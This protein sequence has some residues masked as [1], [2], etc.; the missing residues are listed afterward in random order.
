MFECARD[1]SGVMLLDCGA[2]VCVFPR[3]E[4]DKVWKKAARIFLGNDEYVETEEHGNHP[5]WGEGVV[6][7]GRNGSLV[8]F[9]RAV[10]LFNVDFDNGRNVFT[11]SDKEEGNPVFSA[12]CTNGLYPLEECKTTSKIFRVGIVKQE[13]SYQ[14]K[15]LSV[16]KE[17]HKRLAHV[18]IRRILK[19]VQCYEGFE[20]LEHLVLPSPEPQCLPCLEAENGI[21]RDQFPK[22]AR[23]HNPKPGPQPERGI[24]K[25]V[26][27]GQRLSL[28]ILFVKGNLYLF[29][30]EF[31]TNLLLLYRLANKKRESIFEGIR[32]FVG[33]LK[34]FGD[35]F[36]RTT[37]IYSDHEVVFSNLKD[38]LTLEGITLHQSAPYEHQSIIETHVRPL[39]RYMIAIER[40]IFA[41]YQLL[42]P[43]E[44]HPYLLEYCV[45]MM[46]L[47]PNSKT[48]TRSDNKPPYLIARNIDKIRVPITFGTIACFRDPSQPINLIGMVIGISL[49]SSS[50]LVYF[51]QKKISLAWRRRGVI[52]QHDKIPLWFR[53]FFDKGTSIKIEGISLLDPKEESGAEPFYSPE[54]LEALPREDEQWPLQLED[55]STS[56]TIDDSTIEEED[57]IQEEIIQEDLPEE[58]MAE[59]QLPEG[60]ENLRRSSRTRRSTTRS[61]YHYFLFRKEA[62]TLA[63]VLKMVKAVD[64]GVLNDSH[65]SIAE[66]TEL[67]KEDSPR[68][69][70]AAKIVELDNV[71]S[72]DTFVPQDSASIP[73]D[74]N[75]IPCS[76]IEARKTTASGEF[77]S[78]KGR[79]VAGGH[80]DEQ[81]VPTWSPTVEPRNVMLTLNVGLTMDYGF[82]V[83]DV[84][85]AYL[86]ATLDRPVYMRIP[87]KLAS[88]L[89]TLKPEWNRFKNSNGSLI[90]LLKKALY[91]LADSGRQF[92]LELRKFLVEDM[93]FQQSKLDK[94]VYWRTG[95]TDGREWIHLVNTHVDDLL[96]TA[97][98]KQREEFAAKLQ[99]RFGSIKHQESEKGDVTFLNMLLQFL[100]PGECLISQPDLVSKIVKGGERIEKYPAAKDINKVDP[101]SPMMDDPLAFRS[102]LMQIQYLDR[103]RPDI[104]MAQNV[105]ATRMK[106]PSMQDWE[107]LE[108]LVAYIRGT[109]DYVLR[110]APQDGVVNPPSKLTDAN[111]QIW[112]SADASY[113]EN[114][115]RRSRTGYVLGIGCMPNAPIVCKSV[116]QTGTAVSSTEA[117]LNALFEATK[118]GIAARN[119]MLEKGFTQV[120][121][122]YEQDNASAI[123]IAETG[124]TQ[125]K[126]TKHMD[127]RMNYI[128]ERIEDKSIE[129]VKV[130][131]HD[132]LADY[133][134]KV[135]HGRK[136]I[137]WRKRIMNHKY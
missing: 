35:H 63:T 5:I 120:A 2:N 137:E 4:C 118:A 128:T 82:D 49:E 54:M 83:L 24:P 106:N 127:I 79:L 11:L 33:R 50:V 51:P 58:P 113:G 122:P 133:L 7:A 85:S 68:G 81:D 102:G 119:W 91:G 6:M 66:W 131:T 124:V 41:N 52:L 14:E 87:P 29:G 69:I 25:G 57:D 115:D 70:E 60:Q 13:G 101:L 92:Y 98:R 76:M 125:S 55:P 64:S 8:A 74:T 90:V 136:W 28:D 61:E 40:Q 59:V 16:L 21:F 86:C 126:R 111:L 44:L 56:Q 107:H 71:L 135:E 22:R 19:C 1:K 12:V 15:L 93:G 32:S 34:S 48:E 9:S 26:N 27:L 20:D 72:Y 18:N 78:S 100:K 116:V 42:L 105:L 38:E 75:I 37:E 45:Q 47:V 17:L 95:T 114:S 3:N 88:T 53:S 84:K 97:P 10:E 121:I 30:A 104:K 109:K 99:K 103:S 46:N 130:G 65:R 80:R 89:C 96:S 73:K 67:A 132:M 110:V 23:T 123:L 62:S 77:I 39:R 129:L 94:A 31:T 134:T 108:H 36:Q 117:E 112:A 43:E